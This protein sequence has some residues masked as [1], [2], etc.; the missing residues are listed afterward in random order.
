MTVGIF[1]RFTFTKFTWVQ[2]MPRECW[3]EQPRESISDVPPSSISLEFS[4]SRDVMANWGTSDLFRTAGRW[5][6][7]AFV[8]TPVRI[9]GHTWSRKQKTQDWFSQAKV[10][11]IYIYIHNSFYQPYSAEGGFGVFGTK[12]I[13]DNMGRALQ[14]LW[15]KPFH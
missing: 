1:L 15:V 8:N 4:T 7:S 5:Y 14:S 12:M 3:V 6:L 10:T 2:K 13:P 11:S 9:E